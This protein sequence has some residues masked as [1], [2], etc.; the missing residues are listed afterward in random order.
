MDKLKLKSLPEGPYSLASEHWSRLS[1]RW[2]GRARYQSK[3]R[4]GER[5]LQGKSGTMTR[6]RRMMGK[7]KE[8]WP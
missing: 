3:E 4:E 5:I 7:A 8:Q 6:G 2:R 1:R